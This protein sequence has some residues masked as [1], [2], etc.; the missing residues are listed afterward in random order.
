[1]GDE[2]TLEKDGETGSGFDR[3]VGVRGSH[4][5][6]GQKQR[7]AIS[8][9]ILRNPQNLLLEE[10][11]SALDSK[12][13]QIVQESLNTIM[14]GRTTISITHRIHTI[15]SSERIYVLERGRVVEEGDYEEL[16]EAGGHFHHLGSEFG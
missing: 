14:K 1:M 9:A 15:K 7:V 8:R 16:M 12:D 6:R 3:N 10:A 5:S 2:K 13:E 4:I 11:T